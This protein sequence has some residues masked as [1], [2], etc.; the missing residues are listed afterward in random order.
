MII[1]SNNYFFISSFDKR[2]AFLLSATPFHVY[3]QKNNRYSAKSKTKM[4]IEGTFF[5]SLE[6]KKLPLLKS[7][8]PFYILL[9]R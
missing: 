4:F 6:A 2:L 3:K 9:L 7:S 8:F 5:T 1:E